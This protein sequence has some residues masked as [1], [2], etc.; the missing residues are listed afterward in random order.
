MA[1]LITRPGAQEPASPA[2]SLSRVVQSLLQ[3]LKSIA[4]GDQVQDVP[5][6]ADQAGDGQPALALA[7]QRHQPEAVALVQLTELAAGPLVGQGP[8]DQGD[9]AAGVGPLG[10]LVLREE[11]PEDLV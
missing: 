10:D 7:V 2:G 5:L 9:G 8:L 3:L 4:P 1:T 6:L 11:A